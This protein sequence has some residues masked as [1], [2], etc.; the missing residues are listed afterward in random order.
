MAKYPDS[1]RTENFTFGQSVKIKRG[2]YLG[3]EGVVANE[4]DEYGFRKYLIHLDSTP[5]PTI[6]EVWVNLS[7]LTEE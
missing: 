7:D 4:S 6:R 1:K 3:C 2:F 5:I